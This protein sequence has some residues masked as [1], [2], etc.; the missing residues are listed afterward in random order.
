M[1]TASWAEVYRLGFIVERNS[2]LTLWPWEPVSVLNTSG[3][4]TKGG[5]NKR[6]GI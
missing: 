5:G 2:L 4:E 1:R 3:H 6:E